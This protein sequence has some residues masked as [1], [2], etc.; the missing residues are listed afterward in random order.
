MNSACRKRRAEI[1]GKLLQR[2]SIYSLPQLVFQDEEEFYLEV[3]T[4]RQNNW[5][6]LNGSKKDVQLERLC[7]EENK[8]LKKV[9]VSAVITWKGVS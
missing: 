9:M 7:S 5:I 1:A 4:N 3:P 6:Y 8:F 2:F